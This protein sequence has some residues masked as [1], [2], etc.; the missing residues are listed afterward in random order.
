VRAGHE[1]RH[2]GARSMGKLGGVPP[3]NRSVQV[4]RM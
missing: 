4:T 3:P 2:P 1:G